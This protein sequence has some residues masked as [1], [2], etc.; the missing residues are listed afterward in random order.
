MVGG[1][2]VFGSVRACYENGT[3]AS[4]ITLYSARVLNSENRFDNET[5]II[6]QMR[7]AIQVFTAAPYSCRVF[8]LSLGDNVAWLQHNDRQSLWAESLDILAREYNVLLVVSA[9]NHNLGLGFSSDDAEEVVTTYPD[10]LFSQEC[11]LCEPATAVIPITVGG[12]ADEATPAVPSA[13]QADDMN[14]PIAEPFQPSPTSRIGPGVNGAI[15]PEF[16]AAAG[17]TTFKGSSVIRQVDDDPGMAIMSFSHRP[18]E[19]LFDFD[20]GTSYA[21]PIVARSASLLWKQLEEQFGEEPQANLVRAVLAASATV[22]APTADL[23]HDE[24]GLEGIRRVCGYGIIDEE[25]AD[26]SADRRVTLVHRGEIPL[27]TFAVFEVPFPEEL[28]EATGKKTVTV[29]L[30]FDPPVR[31]R[32]A[33]YIGVKMDYALIRGRSLDEIVEAYRQLSNEEQTEL[34]DAGQRAQGAFQSPF[35]CDLKPG[36][37]ALQASTLQRSSWTFSRSKAEY[38]DSYFLVVRA[39]RGWAPETFTHQNYAVTLT[40]EADEPE[41]YNL[42]Q[43]RIRLRQQQ[44]AR[45]T[46]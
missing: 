14:R 18:T 38:G 35:K 10:F 6:H 45:A 13:S 39:Q 34:R 26:S 23:L 7:R 32:R 31:R 30:A 44:R 40:L 25:F 20:I 11:G 16:V 36:P 37:Q 4:P 27:D 43:N 15:K 22:P 3:F 17:N 8:N 19:Q 9:G 12:I 2:A 5:L 29:S 1:L 21:A 28:R 24:H 33:E 42:I 46:R 41:L